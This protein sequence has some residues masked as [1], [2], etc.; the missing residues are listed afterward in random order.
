MTGT[1]PDSLYDLA[2]LDHLN[3]SENNF[4]GVLSSRIGKLSKLEILSIHTNRFSGTIPSELGL[5]D[6]LCKLLCAQCRHHP[7]FSNSL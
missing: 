2:S 1:I 6:R 7:G 3:L 4:Y 5:C